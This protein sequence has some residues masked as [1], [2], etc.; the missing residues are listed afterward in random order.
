MMAITG[1]FGMSVNLETGVVDRWAFRSTGDDGTTYRLADQ[2]CP[3][4]GSPCSTNDRITQCLGERCGWDDA[5]MK[6]G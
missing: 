2:R 3:I 1:G 5:G 4:C 6:H